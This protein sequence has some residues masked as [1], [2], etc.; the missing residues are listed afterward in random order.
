[1]ELN[2]RYNE[3]FTFCLESLMEE[4]ECLATNYKAYNFHLKKYFIVHIKILPVS[5]YVLVSLKSCSIPNLRMFVFVSS[6]VEN[7]N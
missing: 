1:M 5:A 2:V 7:M 6:G 3:S 4:F